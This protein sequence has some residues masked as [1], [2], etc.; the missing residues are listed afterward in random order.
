[1]T[2]ETIKSLPI[3]VFYQCTSITLGEK[4]TELI[5]LELSKRH[6]DLK[7]FQQLPRS[8]SFVSPLGTWRIGQWFQTTVTKLDSE[9]PVINPPNKPSKPTK[10]RFSPHVDDEDEDEE[11]PCEECYNAPCTC[12][13][14]DEDDDEY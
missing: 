8:L 14:D 13:D 4:S 9:P 2:E 6:S 12:C 5:K 10:R 7:G 1:M 11:D 3:S